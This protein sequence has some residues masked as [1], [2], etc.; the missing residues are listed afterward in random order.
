[1]KPLFAPNRVNYILRTY[2][3][4]ERY[5]ERIAEI[6]RFCRETGTRHV[7]LFP[8]LHFIVWNQLGLDDARR[9]AA[10]MNRIK[11]RLA[12][13]GIRIGIN[14]SYNQSACRWDHRGRLDY[15]YWATHADGTCDHTL[16]CLLD[17]KLETYLRGFYTILAEIGPDYIY[18]DDDH[19]YMLQGIRNTW[20]CACELHLK[21]FG[22]RT[23]RAWTRD[24]LNE[25]L[26]KDPDVH[27]VW[28]AFLGQRLV[29]LAGIIADTV[30][31]VNPS[32]EVGMME[33]SVHALPT[34]GHNL[35]NMMRAFKPVRRPLVRP[36]IGPYFDINHGEIIPGLFYMEHAAHVLGDNPCYTPEVDFCTGSRFSKSM[37][38]VRLHIM[39]GLLNRMNNP[40]ISAN[41]YSG[42]SPFL[43]PAVVPLLRDN[44]KYFEAVRKNAPERGTRKGIQFIWHFDSAQKAGRPIGSVTDLYWPAFTC[45]DIFGHLGFA[46]TYDESPVRFLAGESVR[47]LERD[48]IESM[49]RGGVILDIN[50][51]RALQ[52]MGFGDPL[53]CRIGG[54]LEGFAAEHLVAE[55]M[56]G[57]YTNTYIP[58]MFAATDSVFNLEPGPS[59]R[60]LSRITDPDCR[61]LAPGLVIHQNPGGGKIALLPY[62]L[63]AISPTFGGMTHLVCYHRRHMLKAILDWMNPDVLPLWVEEPSLIA[64]QTWDNGKHLTACL[65]N[66][67]F[68]PAES[69]T[70]LLPGD[71]SPEKACTINPRGRKTSLSGRIT[72][73]AMEGGKARWT[74]RVQLSAFDPFLLMLER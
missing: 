27:S 72:R 46:V 71:L 61:P 22:E 56:C 54:P 59:A 21:Q 10:T 45:H 38:V 17:P 18:V 30:H 19:R 50:A 49:L 67:S 13:E 68:D 69:L 40:A 6:I 28:I 70:I 37:Q 1:M 43:E 48:R 5:D 20:G 62:A 35:E 42:D 47:C 26:C 39:Q 15:D 11:E 2:I 64:V 24:R 55:D 34:M 23:G 66:A 41:S 73:T 51:A 53:G 36:C 12:V 16:P 57:P 3:P 58:L 8:D 7:M 32:I 14:S 29:Q 52:D 31:A 60:V 9:E 65:I 33:P 63:Q 44:R 4:H 25:T 74:L